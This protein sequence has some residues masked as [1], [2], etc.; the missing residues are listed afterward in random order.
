ME[1][2]KSPVGVYGIREASS[3]MG[4]AFA[5]EARRAQLPIPARDLFLQTENQPLA[6]YKGDRSI[7]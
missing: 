6:V 7:V 5:R 4:S 1:N 3:G 2:V